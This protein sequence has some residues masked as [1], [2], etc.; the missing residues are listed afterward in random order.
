MTKAQMKVLELVKEMRAEEAKRQYVPHY[1]KR[2]GQMVRRSYDD[3]VD[4]ERYLELFHGQGGIRGVKVFKCCE[5]GEMVDYFQ[6]EAWC[7]DFD[8]EDGCICDECY[9]EEM[10]DDL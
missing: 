2:H 4:T 7:C 3:C 5:C 1:Y 9:A 6:L 10:G 8:H